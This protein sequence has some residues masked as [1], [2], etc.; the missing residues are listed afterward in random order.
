[1]V[2]RE[3]I[4]EDPAMWLAM[5]RW[6]FLPK[7][8]DQLQNGYQCPGHVRVRLEEDIARLLHLPTHPIP[9]DG[10][11]EYYFLLDDWSES[12]EFMNLELFPIFAN[13]F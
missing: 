8:E 12:G 3:H 5:R 11:L 9:E 7:S 4:L 10:L 6:Q 1:M 2:Q 13:I